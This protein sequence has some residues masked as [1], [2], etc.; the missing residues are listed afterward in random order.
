[1]VSCLVKYFSLKIVYEELPK[2]NQRYIF[3]ASPHGYL[4]LGQ[5]LMTFLIN[6]CAG[7]AF[8]GLTASTAFKIPVLRHLVSWMGYVDAS[9]ETALRVL[10]QNKS[11]AIVI[12]GI[13]EIFENSGVGKT[14]TLL[15]K[16]R[17]GFVQLA[18][19]TGTPIVCTY[20][21]GNTSALTVA[22]DRWGIMQS[23]SRKIQFT[24]A[25]PT[26]RF[27]LPIPF[28]S[29]ITVVVSK[30]IEVPK[31]DNPSEEDIQQVLDQVME[32]MRASFK[33]HK[34]AYGWGEKQLILK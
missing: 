34:Q 22:T 15:I 12:G 11:I 5:A 27:N 31:K 2:P 20:C 29:P 17:K 33:S 7:L 24:V 9:K 10:S 3:V 1:L 16:Q 19:K 6:P 8:V 30:A 28:R 32:A 4:P 23:L 21:F 14:E 18:F 25:A 26:G 13:A